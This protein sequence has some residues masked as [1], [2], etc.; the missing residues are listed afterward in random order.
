MKIRVRASTCLA[1]VALA[2]AV[3]VGAAGC[4]TAGDAEGGLQPAGVDPFDDGGPDGTRGGI[5]AS[6]AEELAAADGEIVT[7]A[8]VVVDVVEP[9]TFTFDDPN[10]DDPSVLVLLQEDVVVPV[11]ADAIELTGLA[12]ATL[13]LPAAEVRTGRDLD[14][15]L[16]Q[17]HEGRPYLE[18]TVARADS[19]PADY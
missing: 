8:G 7:L 4:G 11:G 2:A 6:P 15:P 5:D 9:G 19:G 18:A 12:H 17:R 16:Y 10:D 13:D 14:D 1:V 3:S